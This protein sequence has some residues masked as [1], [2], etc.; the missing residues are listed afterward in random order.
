MKTVTAIFGAA[1]FI[2]TALIFGSRDFGTVPSKTDRKHYGKRSRYHNGKRFTYPDEWTENGLSDDV[3]VSEKAVSPKDKLP[4]YI[5]DFTPTIINK[6]KVTWFGHSSVL[7]QIHGMNIL[8]DPIF[9][10]RCSPFQWI[11]PKRFTRP[12]VDIC[13]LPHIDVVLLSHDHYDHLDRRTVKQ[14]EKKTD[15]FIV[16]LGLEKHLKRWYIPAKKIIPLAWWEQANI[17]GL[18]L[19]CTPSRHFSGRGI[20][21]QNSTQWCSWVIRDE[22]HS[23]FYSG[24]GSIGGH[25]EA[26]KQRFG[27]FNLALMEC[28]QYNR[29]WHYSHLYPEESVMCAEIIGAEKVMPI[30]WGAFVLSNHGWDDSPERFVREAEKRKLNVITPHICETVCI[31]DDLYTEYWW[32]NYN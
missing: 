28:G 29:N 16:S 12:S 3:W 27:N 31:D 22:Y 7:L 8:T 32:R 5:P 21:G 10:E 13:Q 17:N 15:C 6:V 1:A 30:H 4:V 25:F 14:L 19:I 26:V 9:S 20:I 2:A 24:D 18:E 23:I 11:G